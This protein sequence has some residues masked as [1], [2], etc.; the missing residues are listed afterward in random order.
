MFRFLLH[1]EEFHISGTVVTNRDSSSR[2]GDGWL[3]HG[4]AEKWCKVGGLQIALCICM[5]GIHSL[6]VLR[7]I[8]PLVITLKYVAVHGVRV[9]L[10][11]SVPAVDGSCCCVSWRVVTG[12]IP[13]IPASVVVADTPS[14]I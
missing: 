10:K 7:G 5:Q 13:W 2:H 4:R 9:A 6:G 8:T 3:P 14:G 11:V 1:D 12:A